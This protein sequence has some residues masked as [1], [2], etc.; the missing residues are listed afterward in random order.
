MSRG[1]ALAYPTANLGQLSAASNL[2][3]SRVIWLDGS[4]GKLRKDE[5]SAFYRAIET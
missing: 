1:A 5:S 2:G 4:D 3:I